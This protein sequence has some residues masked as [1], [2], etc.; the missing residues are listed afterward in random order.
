MGC[1]VRVMFAL[2]PGEYLGDDMG[3]NLR[4]QR[5]G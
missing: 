5:G 1:L 2:V 3:L 4:M